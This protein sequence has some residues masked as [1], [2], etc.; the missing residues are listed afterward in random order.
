MTKRRSIKILM[1]IIEAC[2]EGANVTKVV[3]SSGLNFNT[4]RPYLKAMTEHGILEETNDTYKATERGLEALK[5]LKALEE[6]IPG[7]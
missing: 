6:M 4:I 3:Y 2:Q 5:H 1:Q 7:Y